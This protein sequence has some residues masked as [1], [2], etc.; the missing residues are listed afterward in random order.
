MCGSVSVVACVSVG[1]DRCTGS[2]R[3]VGS[4]FVGRA[5]EAVV[6]AGAAAGLLVLIG[7]L[8]V[9][10]LGLAEPAGAIDV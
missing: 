4:D 6:C 3:D 5:F 7:G 1:S 2:V 9:L 8:P 10:V